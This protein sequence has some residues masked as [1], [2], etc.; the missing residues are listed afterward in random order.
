MNK[1]N[2]TGGRL[3]AGVDGCKA[4]WF[5]VW[6]DGG[7]DWKCGVFLDILTLWQ[8]LKEA[9]L[10]LVDIPIGLP[11][12]GPRLCDIEARKRLGRP[13]GSSVFPAPCR[14]ALSAGSHAAASTINRKVLGKGITIQCWGIC[15]K[16]CEVDEM[17]LSN[18]K[19][20]EVIREGHPEVAFLIFAGVPMAFKKSTPEGVEVRLGVLRRRWPAVDKLFDQATARHLRKDVGRDDILDAAA[21]YL[22]AAS[23]AGSHQ[24]IPE[25]PEHDR[26]GLPMEMVRSGL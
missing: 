26:L 21:M 11:S 15:P 8:S 22:T 16:I 1:L 6:G 18:A 14:E 5:A 4:G 13:R 2:R 7:P 10:I 25:K 9:K 24:T 19:A 20:R 23:P 3:V 17:L 12:V